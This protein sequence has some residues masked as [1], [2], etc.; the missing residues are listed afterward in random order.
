MK[1]SK[2]VGRTPAQAKLPFLICA[3]ILQAEAVFAQVLLRWALQQGV[4]VIPHGPKQLCL[5]C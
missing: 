2:R 4:A 3:C 5:T 1:V